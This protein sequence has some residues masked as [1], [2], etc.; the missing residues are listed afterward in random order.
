MLFGS[1]FIVVEVCALGNK[2]ISW[3]SGIEPEIVFEGET[4]HLA[5]FGQL[6]E[7][8]FFEHAE[9]ERDSFDD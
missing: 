1:Y 6:W 7:G 8:F 3:F 2:V 9:P 5:L 4:V